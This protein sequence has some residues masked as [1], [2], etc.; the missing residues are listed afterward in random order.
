MSKRKK[1][2][3]IQ[4][5]ESDGPPLDLEEWARRYVDAVLESQG[6]PSSGLGAEGSP[7]TTRDMPG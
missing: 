6:F 1:P 5:V 2:V 3:R 4:V 7:P